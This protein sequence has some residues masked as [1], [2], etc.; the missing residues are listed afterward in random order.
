MNWPATDIESV[1]HWTGEGTEDAFYKILNRVV[2]YNL[3]GE[4]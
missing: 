4:I 1:T 2:K 3:Y